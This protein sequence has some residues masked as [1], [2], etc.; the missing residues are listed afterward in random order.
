MG[1]PTTACTTKQAIGAFIKEKREQKQLSTAAL[2][3][4]LDISVRTYER[5][6][7]GE[8]SLKGLRLFAVAV[9]LDIDPVSMLPVGWLDHIQLH[10]QL[11]IP[12]RSPCTLSTPHKNGSKNCGGESL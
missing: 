11:R 8:G 10:A 1:N 9:F 2:A 3:D 12:L 4:F 5:F 7:K 6:E